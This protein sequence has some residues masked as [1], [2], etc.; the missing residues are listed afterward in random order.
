MQHTYPASLKLDGTAD[1]TA[2]SKYIGR[3]SRYRARQQTV[4]R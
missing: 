2:I 1:G 4:V 3:D